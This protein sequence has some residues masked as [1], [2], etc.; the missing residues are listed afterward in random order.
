MKRLALIVFIL[1]MAGLL[2]ACSQP[3][4]T[5]SSELIRPGDMVG[6]FLVT[7]GEEGNFTYGFEGD[8]SEAG[9][10]TK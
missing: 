9:E 4:P 7:T 6:D 3:K 5:E 1:W 8:C 2:V 10:R